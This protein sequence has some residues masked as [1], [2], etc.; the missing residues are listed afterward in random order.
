MAAP[1]NAAKCEESPCQPGA[2]HTWHIA[3]FPCAAEFGCCR[4]TTD[5]GQA[6]PIKGWGL[7]R[8]G[9]FVEPAQAD[10]TCPVPSQKIFRFW[11]RANHFYNSRVLLLEGAF[12]DRH[13]RGVEC[14]GRGC[15]L[16]EWRRRGRRSRV[17]LAPR[18]WRQVGGGNSADDGDKKARS[19]GRARR[20]PLKPLRAGMPGDPGGPVVT[21]L[22]WFLFFPREAAGALGTRHSPRPPGGRKLS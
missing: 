3:S 20:K 2:V 21:T 11:R 8:N 9:E 10:A 5:I 16:D 15:A 22:V 6:A 4:G 12:R 17:V 13:E 19:P 14:G 18:R 7:A 1:T